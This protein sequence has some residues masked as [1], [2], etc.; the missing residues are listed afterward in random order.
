MGLS[1]ANAKA[2]YQDDHGRVIEIVNRSGE[3]VM[4]GDKPVSM[5]I[6]GPYSKRVRDFQREESKRQAKRQ[7][8]RLSLEDFEDLQVRQM[9]VAVI[10]W[11]G[12]V[13]D[14][15]NPLQCTQENVVAVLKGIPYLLEQL[16]LAHR[17]ERL[18]STASPSS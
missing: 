18:F 14:H 12:I 7:Q 9:A 6:L 8:A 17:D 1:I 3:P 10:D 11:S 16:Q 15:G 13:D 2:E 4:D 5:T